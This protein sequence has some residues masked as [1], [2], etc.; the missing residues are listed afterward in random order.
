MFEHLS[1]FRHVIVTGPHRSGTTIA[2][3]MIAEDAAKQFVTESRIAEPRFEG[4]DEPYLNEDMVSQ[5]LTI[6]GHIALQ[7]ATCWR[8]IEK[9]QRPDMA[10]VFIIRSPEDTR[11]SQVRYRGRILD[12]PEAKLAEWQHMRAKGTI[13]NPFTVGYS[14]LAQHP[15]FVADRTGWS[16]RQIAPDAADIRDR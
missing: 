9:L 10:T 6:H 16:P 3:K 11:A 13:T 5:W 12:S 14:Q 4:D 8:W 1:E 2:A 7:G 15:L